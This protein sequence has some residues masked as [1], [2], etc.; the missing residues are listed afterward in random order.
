MNTM[1][2][3]GME[4]MSGNVSL[5][6]PKSKRVVLVGGCF[7][8]LHYGHITFLQSAK[9]RG[10]ILVVALENDD[11]I[12]Q[13]KKRDPFHTM[14]QRAE[15]LTN[16]RSVDVVICLPLFKTTE[17]YVRFVSIIKPSVIA[18]TSSDAFL[19]QK[20]IC[21]EAIG[22]EVIEVC[23]PVRGLSSSTLLNYAHLL[24]D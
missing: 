5:P 15:I 12:R 14:K 2:L 16:L 7:D 6:W 18:V 10:D 3:D 23:D 4:F 24:H 9:A 8:V 20:K 17:E 21:A 1:I 22:S 11:F 19:T 13:R